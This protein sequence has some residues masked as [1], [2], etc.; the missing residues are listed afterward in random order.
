MFLLTQAACLGLVAGLL[1]PKGEMGWTCSCC[2]ATLGL[3]FGGVIGADVVGINVCTAF[4]QFVA[5]ETALEISFAG[6]NFKPSIIKSSLPTPSS[7]VLDVKPWS[8]NTCRVRLSFKMCFRQ[9]D[10]NNAFT[11]HTLVVDIKFLL[12]GTEPGVETSVPKP[13]CESPQCGNNVSLRAAIAFT[14]GRV[15]AHIRAKKTAKS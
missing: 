15:V 1:L 14:V 12:A 2:Q 11:S 6:P 10:F 8:R 4:E 7:D 13:N 9:S 3:G 5:F